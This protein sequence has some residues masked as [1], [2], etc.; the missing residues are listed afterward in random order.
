MCIMHLCAVLCLPV[1]ICLCHYW[2]VSLPV[3]VFEYRGVCNSLVH[4]CVTCP[5]VVCRWGFFWCDVM[6]RCCLP[7]FVVM[8][9]YVSTG[10]QVTGVWLRNQLMLQGSTQFLAVRGRSPS[11]VKAA[12]SGSNILAGNAPATDSGVE[13]APRTVRFFGHAIS[14]TMPPTGK[15]VSLTSD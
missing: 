14:T 4:Q 12:P 13:V 2:C 1:Q 10:T 9:A 15:G 6:L 11:P 3:C 5:D 8:S 7:L